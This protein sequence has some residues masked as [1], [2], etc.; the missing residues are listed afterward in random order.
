[1]PYQT[2]QLNGD[3]GLDVEIEFS[4]IV[5][6]YGGGF[7]D[8]L[9]TGHTDG[10][11]FYRL[12]YNVLPDSQ[13]QHVTDPEDMVDKPKATYLWDFYVKRKQGD[14]FFYVKDPR[15]G[16]DVLVRFVDRRLSFNLFGVKLF[17]SRIFL[18]QVRPRP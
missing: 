7:V 13:G 14:P 4:E 10:Q 15:T 1:M 18:A 2:L 16:L 8:I 5:Q 17:S 3:F 12:V 6:D 9:R 11:N